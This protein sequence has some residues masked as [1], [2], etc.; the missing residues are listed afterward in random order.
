MEFNTVKSV[1]P[2]SANT[3]LH[4]GAIPIDPKTNGQLLS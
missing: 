1:T 2:T 3:A 4:T